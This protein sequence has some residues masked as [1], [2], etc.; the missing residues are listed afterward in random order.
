M[1]VIDEYGCRKVFPTND[2]KG[3]YIALCNRSS[4]PITPSDSPAKSFR[5]TSLKRSFLEK[6]HCLSALA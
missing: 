1:M 3:L 6:G 5:F 2:T 4:V